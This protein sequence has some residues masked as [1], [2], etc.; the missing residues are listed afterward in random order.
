MQ[1]EIDDNFGGVPDGHIFEISDSEDSEEWRRL[2]ADFSACFLQ[3]TRKQDYDFPDWH[4]GMRGLCVY[5]YNGEFYKATFINT[6]KLILDE[7]KQSY[8]QF[9]CYERCG[10]Q[11]VFVGCFMVFKERVIFDR[12]SEEKG[13]I[14]RLVITGLPP[15]KSSPGR[16]F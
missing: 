1:I 16:D 3:F 9:E 5:L 13:L 10:A 2:L 6:I 8:A 14:K 15:K 12:T 7:V 4:H 11:L